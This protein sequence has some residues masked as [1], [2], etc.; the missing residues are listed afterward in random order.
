MK[1]KDLSNICCIYIDI[2]YKGSINNKEN[3][4]KND[5]IDNINAIKKENLNNGIKIEKL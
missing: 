2:I 3:K 5:E 4:F 1:Y